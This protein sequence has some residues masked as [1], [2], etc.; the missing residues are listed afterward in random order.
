MI[1]FNAENKR[2]KK[3]HFYS[4]YP[5]IDVDERCFSVPLCNFY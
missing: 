1:E 4:G 3:R 5:V 2:K